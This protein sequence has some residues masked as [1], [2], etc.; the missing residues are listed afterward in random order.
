MMATWE[1]EAGGGLL[2]AG[3]VPGL[4]FKASL[5]YKDPVS[6]NQNIQAHIHEHIHT[7]THTHMNT[8]I[9]NL[10]VEKF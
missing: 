4:E 8:Y 5:H 3:G 6:E 9:H 1:A 7:W 10:S 2:R